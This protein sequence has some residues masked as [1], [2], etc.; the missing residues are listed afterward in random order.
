MGKRGQVITLLLILGRS[1]LRGFC[2][3]IFLIISSAIGKKFRSRVII[4]PLRNVLI[5]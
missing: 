1:D 5:L 3:I 2:L 4:C